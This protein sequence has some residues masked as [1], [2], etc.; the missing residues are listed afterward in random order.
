MKKN[1]L[2]QMQKVKMTDREGSEFAMYIDLR[3]GDDCTYVFLSDTSQP[4][5][6]HLAQDA[7]FHIERI[8]ERLNLDRATS[9][10]YRHIY[11]EQMG[12]TFGRFTVDWR[13]ESGPRYRFQ[14]LTS[15]DDLQRIGH[16][17]ETSAPIS[18]QDQVARRKSA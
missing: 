8:V 1:L 11:Q 5:T 14:M 16:I 13:H 15:G 7:M 6:S 17:I 12:S 3:R 10:F 9:V 4:G 2:P 18:L